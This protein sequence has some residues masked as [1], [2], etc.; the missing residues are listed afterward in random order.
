MDGEGATLENAALTVKNGN[1][2]IILNPS[3]GLQITN[4]DVAIPT[5][6]TD[7]NGNLTLTGTLK[8]INPNDSNAGYSISSG[9]ISSI[10]GVISLN[11]DGSGKAGGISWDTAGNVT[12]NNLTANNGTFSG[13][14]YAGNIKY[15]DSYGYFSGSGLSGTSVEYGKLTNNCVNSLRA[16]LI[17]TNELEATN[18]RVGTIEANYISASTVY[19]QFVEV[20][21]LKAD[22]ITAG[23]ITTDSLS[24]QVIQTN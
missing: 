10:N 17:T 3:V 16:N 13:S 6:K 21:N 23:A 11:T 12:I 7:T 8:A 4:K 5:F 14:V 15:G 24:A 1:A 20:K 2:S 18:A 9:T 22:M 19:A